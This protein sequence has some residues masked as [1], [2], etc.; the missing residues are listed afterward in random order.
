[1]GWQTDAVVAGGGSYDVVR[2]GQHGAG[3]G[4]RHGCGFGRAARRGLQRP[5]RVPLR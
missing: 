3:G 4:G 5:A 2:V 1:M